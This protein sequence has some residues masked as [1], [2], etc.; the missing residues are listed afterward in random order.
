MK[1]R[2]ISGVILVLIAAIIIAAGVLITPL[3][4]TAAAAF[5][6]AVAAFE[7]LRNAAGINSRAAVAGACV[8]SFLTV[9]ALDGTTAEALA[10]LFGENAPDTLETALAL[11]I[12]YFIFGAVM[13]LIK[14]RFFGMAQIAALTAFP[15]PLAFAFSCLALVLN[16]ENGVYYLLLLL[17]FSSIC[18]MGAYFVGSAVGKHK[19]CP[20]ISPHKTVEGAFGGIASSVVVTLALSFAFSFEDRLAAALIL[21]VAFCILGMVGDLFASSIKRAVGIKDYGKLIP[22]HGGILDRFDSIIMIAPLFYLF[23]SAGII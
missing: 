20:E 16:H 9:F 8:Y 13:T 6:A 15:I 23:I 4:I 3:F 11:S 1:T 5:L 19:L 2:I 12:A 7:L 10:P 22:G 18:D 21:T 17:N 14:H